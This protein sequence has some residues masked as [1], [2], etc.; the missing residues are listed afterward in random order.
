MEESQTK[1][2]HE[3]LGSPRHAAA[4]GANTVST[5]STFEVRVSGIAAPH[6]EEREG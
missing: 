4:L 5:S 3:W 1:D 6:H 2:V